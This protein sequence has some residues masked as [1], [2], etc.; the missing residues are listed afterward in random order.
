MEELE[1]QIIDPVELHQQM[2]I[3]VAIVIDDEIRYCYVSSPEGLKNFGDWI[4][5]TQVRFHYNF[6][7]LIVVS[8]I[9]EDLIIKAIKHIQ[10]EGKLKQ[11]TSSAN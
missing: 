8:E 9:S 6:S 7:D 5:G 2:A 3:Q 1:I 10:K 4:D 11:C